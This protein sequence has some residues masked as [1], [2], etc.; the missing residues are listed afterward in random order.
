MANRFIEVFE[1]GAGSPFE[2]LAEFTCTE[3][4]PARGSAPNVSIWLIAQFG[5]YCNS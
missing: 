1:F 2:I 4:N 5:P 3:A